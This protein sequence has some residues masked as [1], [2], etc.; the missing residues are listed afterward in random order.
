MVSLSQ[1]TRAVKK[2]EG[3]GWGPRGRKQQDSLL[4]QRGMTLSQ[5]KQQLLLKLL[6]KLLVKPQLQQ[7]SAD[8]GGQG[9]G[10]LSHG[11]APGH[12][13]E[14]CSP[15]KA[16]AALPMDHAGE[17]PQLLVLQMQHQPLALHGCNSGSVVR[18]LGYW[19]TSGMLLG[20]ICGTFGVPLGAIGAEL[21]A[22]GVQLRCRWSVVLCTQC[23]QTL[24]YG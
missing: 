24:N 10:V 1:G 12:E 19:G 18:K 16:H 9:G 15:E 6:L 4:E 23:T 2:M 14:G 21:D 5:E 20:Y 7:E 11:S 22:S 17:G 8:G 13:G 3:V